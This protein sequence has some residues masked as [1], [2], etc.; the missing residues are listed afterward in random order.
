[1][2]ESSEIRFSLAADSKVTVEVFDVRGAQ[3]ATVASESYTKGDHV[4]TLRPPFENGVYFYRFTAGKEIATK[5][6][7]IAK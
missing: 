7:R 2:R 3:L 1:M 4:L 6:F 5:M